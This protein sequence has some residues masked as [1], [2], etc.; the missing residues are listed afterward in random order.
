MQR[1]K[2]G[3][4]I[5]GYEVISD[6]LFAENT[7]SCVYVVGD[8][9]TKEFY[10]LKCMRWTGFAYDVDTVKKRVD[11]NNHVLI[12]SHYLTNCLKVFTVKECPDYIFFVLIYCETGNLKDYLKKNRNLNILMI[13]KI[14]GEITLGLFELHAK[15]I[16]HKNIKPTNVFIDGGVCKLGDIGIFVSSDHTEG[17]YVAPEICETGESETYG[18]PS[19]IFSL[20]A[21]I[22]ELLESRPL[23]RSSD[24]P[25]APLLPVTFVGCMSTPSGILDLVTKMVSA[26]P[27]A[28]PT[29]RDV[30]SHPVIR[31]QIEAFPPHTLPLELRWLY[32]TDNEKRFAALSM[33]PSAFHSSRLVDLADVCVQC[34]VA[35]TYT[36]DALARTP[37]VC[38]RGHLLC[39]GCFADLARIGVCLTAHRGPLTCP[40]STCQDGTFAREAVALHTPEDLSLRLLEKWPVADAGDSK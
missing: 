27:A 16:C 38:S 28:R 21:I 18:F 8:I 24:A 15:I 7:N 14:V 9:E 39:S 3:E 19:D 10:L 32:G 36:D 29:I 31:R 6:E 34:G 22:Y 33:F 1:F 35:E 23:P 17:N 12:K 5:G 26:Q 25:F 13:L 11:F 20:G 37:C 2:K 4:N 30:V 40:W